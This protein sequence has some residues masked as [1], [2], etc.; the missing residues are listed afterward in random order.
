MICADDA[1]SSNNLRL[2]HISTYV[3]IGHT[4]EQKIFYRL[5][6]SNNLH[7]PFLCD[8]PT[9]NKWKESVLFWKATFKESLMKQGP[10]SVLGVHK[11]E[12]IKRAEDLSRDYNHKLNFIS[13]IRFISYQNMVFQLSGLYLTRTWY[14][15]YQVYI[16]PGH[17]ICRHDLRISKY[18]KYRHV[19]AVRFPYHQNFL[20]IYNC[21]NINTCLHKV[22]CGIA[23]QLILMTNSI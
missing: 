19:K 22:C 13:V 20:M 7:A 4:N 16:L 10:I 12:E 8:W 18:I 11:R 21:I 5:T 3:L 9:L 6:I 14:F 1:V 2:I 15:S 17:G 23:G